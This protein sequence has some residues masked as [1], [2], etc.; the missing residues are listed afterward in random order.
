MKDKSD[1]TEPQ[2]LYQIMENNNDNSESSG[3]DSSEQE[4]MRP[5]YV[6]ISDNLKK[7]KQS[8]KIDNLA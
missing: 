3:G 4:E 1:C 8:L 2:T 5:D 6:R 7:I